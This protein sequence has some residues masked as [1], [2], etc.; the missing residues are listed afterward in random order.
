MKRQM[1]L[2]RAILLELEKH[3]H[4]WAPRKL[5]IEGYTDEEV[6]YHVHLMGQAGLLDVADATTRASASPHAVPR[7]ITWAGHEF[8]DA[9]R[10]PS[11][12]EKAKQKVG[13]SLVSVAFDVLKGVLTT[14]AKAQLGLGP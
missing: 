9:A 4:A 8:L 7:A 11:L 14:L 6:G 13:A 1:D 12:W 5:A 2:V 10:D 3:E